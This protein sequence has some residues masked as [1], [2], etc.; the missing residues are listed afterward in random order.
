MD[1][2]AIRARKAGQETP[3]SMAS[4]VKP[5]LKVNQAW[6]D[7][8]GAQVGRVPREKRAYGAMLEVSRANP[9]HKERTEIVDNQDYQAQKVK[10]DDGV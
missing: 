5:D 10:M 4:T 8:P 1:R 6:T 3:G 9:V 2:T 7:C